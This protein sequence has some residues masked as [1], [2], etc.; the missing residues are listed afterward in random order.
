[1]SDPSDAIATLRA[2]LARLASLLDAHG[3][4]WRLAPPTEPLPQAPAVTG[5][6][7]TIAE[8]VALIR[9]LFRGR[10]D[11]YALR[12]ESA[13]TGKSGYA[14]ACANE[15]RPGVC[16][17]PRIKC[18]ACQH[19]VFL[20]VS[21]QVIYD[22]LAG[23][24]TI[25]VYPLLPDNTCRFLAVDFD[26]ADWAAD[27]RAFADSCRDLDVPVSLEISRSGTGAHAW[28]FFA[29]T[30]PAFAAR[31]LGSALLSYTCA[32]TRQLALTS[33]DRLFPNQDIM[34]AGG[35]GNLIALPLQKRARD[36]G[37]TVFVDESLQPYDD[38]WTYLASVRGIQPRDI[39][40][41]VRRAIGNGPALDV[42]RT[43]QDC[44]TEPWLPV[45][46]TTISPDV[47]MPGSVRVTRANQ[48]FVA[49]DEMPQAM[50]NRVIR[51]AAFA[52]PA[53]F[54]AQAMR[55]S[56]WNIPRL[57]AMAERFPVHVALPRGCEDELAAL[58]DAHMIRADFVDERQSGHPIR[59]RFVGCLR[60]PQ[61][62]AVD[63]MLAHETGVLCAPTAFGKTVV[64][65][66]LIATRSARSCL[67]IGRR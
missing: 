65:A 31:E 58:F 22:H 13:T 48:L 3:I 4:E 53:Y 44:A 23:T 24:I 61:Q 63:A 16:E 37:H 12:W 8:K 32:R 41:I 1:M 67:Y 20:P 45:E 29:G 57:I 19:R 59:A 26:D 56:V 33:Y 11:V 17:K 54:E 2:E 38:Q 43:D 14:P 7:L 50:L 35:F 40:T 15:W 66:A 47:T 30:V 62:K 49:T 42:S 6:R 21:D 64:A 39:E 27:A 51:L 46:Q 10:D 34:P 60:Q 18:S 5:A 25:G 28:I 55:R 9:R 36:I 52:N